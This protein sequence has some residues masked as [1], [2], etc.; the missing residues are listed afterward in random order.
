MRA[1]DTTYP[2]SQGRESVAVRA[3]D[4]MPLVRSPARAIMDVE[5]RCVSVAPALAGGRHPRGHASPDPR[6]C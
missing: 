3:D 1:R 4:R 5:K 2:L 6:D